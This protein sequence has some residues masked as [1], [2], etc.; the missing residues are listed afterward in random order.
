MLNHKSQITNYP[1][2]RDP[3][4]QI[5]VVRDKQI[6]NPKSQITNRGFGYRIFGYCILFGICVLCIGISEVS[7][8]N[9][10]MVKMYFLNG[11]YKSCIQE[12]EKIL[13]SAGKRDAKKDELYYIMGLS[14][15]K[16]GLPLSASENFKIILNESRS[17]K[18]KEE[19]KIGLGDSYFMKGDYT[20]AALQY[21]ELI[22][23]NPKT[24]LK[25]A[26]YYRL[27]QLGR[28]TANTDQEKEFLAKLKKEFPL[29]AEARMDKELF[30]L[31][32]QSEMEKKP[33]PAD[34]TVFY[35]VQVGAFSNR[36]NAEHLDRE[37]RNK[38]YTTFVFESLYQNNKIYKVRVGSF[39]NRS[40]AEELKKKLKIEGYPAKI[41]P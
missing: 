36:T 34:S 21:Q 1:A 31:N 33:V 32:T 13:A 16:E 18:F 9:L 28:K 19:A 29:S 22:N 39:K 4:I 12:G 41:Y 8:L 2:K 15:L 38:G 25:A 37:L 40:E 7:A 17:S 6:T 20:L 11:D 23:K 24:K 35:A 30:P 5:H 26:V 27:S 10:N 3:A 14:Y